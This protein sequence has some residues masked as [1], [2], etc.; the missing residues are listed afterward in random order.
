VRRGESRENVKELIAALPRDDEKGE[1]EGG[2]GG[3][4][5]GEN[6]TRYRQSH[7]PHVKELTAAL[8]I[9][10]EKEREERKRERKREMKGRRGEEG[11][12]ELSL[13]SFDPKN[14][15]PKHLDGKER[16]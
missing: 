10:R 13:R 1:G 14:P 12:T 5:G 3:G 8:A 7:F 4:G 2:G 15:H 6:V 16:S 9:K 11:E